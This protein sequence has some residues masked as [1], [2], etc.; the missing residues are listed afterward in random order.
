MHSNPKDLGL[1]AGFLDYLRTIHRL[2]FWAISDSSEPESPGLFSDSPEL[3]CETDFRIV[4]A[5]SSVCIMKM[6]NMICC[7]KNGVVNACSID[8]LT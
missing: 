1:N 5:Y 6:N 7:V 8:V 2:D 4:H 3:D